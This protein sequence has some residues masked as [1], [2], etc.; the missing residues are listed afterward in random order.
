MTV[1]HVLF[2]DYV[3]DVLERREPFRAAHLERIQSHPAIVLAGA[4]G[5]PPHGAAIVFR[6]DDPGEAERFAADDPY[7]VNGLVTAHRV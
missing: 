2:Y 1:H 3:A 5:D 6:T 7:V 4:L